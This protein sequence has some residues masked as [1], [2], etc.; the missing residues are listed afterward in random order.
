MS[1]PISP[2]NGLLKTSQ[3]FASQLFSASTH[4]SKQCSAECCSY[5]DAAL[6]QNTVA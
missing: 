5:V 2:K 6:H 1:Q 4:D 3:N